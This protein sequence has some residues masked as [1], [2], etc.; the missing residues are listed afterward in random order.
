[1]V[2]ITAVTLVFSVVTLFIFEC[3]LGMES[4]RILQTFWSLSVDQISLMICFSSSKV[5]E[6]DVE[7]FFF[8]NQ[9]P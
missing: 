8:F 6:F 2:Q 9:C 1:M 5:V 7:T 4:V 3:G